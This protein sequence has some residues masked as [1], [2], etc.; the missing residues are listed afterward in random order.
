LALNSHRERSPGGIAPIRALVIGIAITLIPQGVWSAL[1]A[2]NLRFAPEIPWAV[3]TMAFLIAAG[4][5]YLRGVWGPSRS[6]ATRR[7]SLRATVVPPLM[8]AWAWL[9]GGLAMIALGGV[10]IVLASMTRMP[11]SVLP[12]LSKYPKWTAVLSV[13]MGALIS[14]LCEQAGIWGYWQEAAER[15]WA[16]GTAIALTAL[17]FALGPH[18]PAGAPF[19]P[20][21]LFFFVTGLVFSAM[22]YV[23]RSI[24]PAIPVHAIGLLAFFLGV[25]PH[26]PERRLVFT[27]GPDAWFWIHV[28]Q[29]VVFTSLAYWAFRKLATLRQ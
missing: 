12:D 13:A 6:A 10:W 20:K 25:W 8:F 9:A 23:T 26:D 4:G 18:P 11:G 7:Q 29:I 1:I 14:P 21:M 24:L 15:R 27:A 2:T 5:Q 19:L 3:L 16:A 17:L 28:A 22:A